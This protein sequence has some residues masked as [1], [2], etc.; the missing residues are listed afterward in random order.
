MK[1]KDLE[2]VLSAVSPFDSPK[3]KISEFKNASIYDFLT[4]ELEQIPTSPHIAARMMF[5]AAY[6][7]QDIEGCSVGDFGCGPGM[8][9]IAAQQL[10]SSYNVGFDVDDD[11][12]DNAWV[13]CR[14]MEIYDIDLVQTDIL[15]LNINQSA[16][17][18]FATL[19]C[20]DSF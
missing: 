2:Y 5:A 16:T 1:L 8:L 19:L 20:T 7:F 4:V 17:S 3:S 10:G 6:T 18:I 14:K 12:L 15:S 9:S 13:N 11:A